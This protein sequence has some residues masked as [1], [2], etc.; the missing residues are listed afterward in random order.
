MDW[1]ERITGFPEEADHAG[2]QARLRVAGGDLVNVVTGRRHAMGRLEL[3]SLAELRRRVGAPAPGRPAPV[4]VVRG[5]VR[6]LH[7]DPAHAGALF[8]VASQFNLLEMVGPGVSPEA[9]VTRYAHDHTQGPACA[10]AAGAAT[11]YRNYLVPLPGGAG[12]TA[13]RQIDALAGLGRA[14]G[15]GAARPLWEWRNGYA[16]CSAAGLAHIRTL[17]EAGDGP[18]REHRREQLRGLLQIGLHHDVEVTDAPASPGQRVS[19][20]FCS[21]LPVAYGRPPAAAWA[22]FARLVLEAAYEATLLAAA[23]NARRGASAQVL[24]TR[25]GGGA[26]G[27][28]AAWIDDAIERALRQCAGLGL[29]VCRVER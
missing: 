8:Q 21:A 23:L 29:D 22:P 19:Q 13:T 1:F 7:L 10:M 9:G 3:V 17:L 5:D 27:N 11:I 20:A 24:L 6:R 12:Q 16:L 26:F 14:L 28:E 18:Q 15:H 4:R 2:T 25:L